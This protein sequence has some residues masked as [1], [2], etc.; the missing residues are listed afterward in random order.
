MTCERE[1]SRPF[2]R[3]SFEGGGRCGF[4]RGRHLEV[5]SDA[6]FGDTR[7]PSSISVRVRPLSGWTEGTGKRLPSELREN[8]LLCSHN[9]SGRSVVTP[10]ADS[11]FSSSTQLNQ[12]PS[13]NTNRLL[14][15]RLYDFLSLG[16]SG[17]SSPS[18]A[19]LSCGQVSWLRPIIKSVDIA[20]R[21]DCA[22][23]VTNGYDA[24][25]H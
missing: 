15:E 6:T 20:L 3:N 22:I 14:A 5:K 11:T 18:H 19:S 21:V 10:I 1:K 17:P 23:V 2:L 7:S 13:R 16:G 9:L 8:L 4:G 24:T 25:S 12:I